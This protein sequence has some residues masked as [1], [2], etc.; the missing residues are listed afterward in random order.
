MQCSS[1]SFP[2]RGGYNNNNFNRSDVPSNWI[3]NQTIGDPNDMFR[4]ISSIS[5][6]TSFDQAFKKIDPIIEKI[7]YIN[8]NDVLHN[9]LG[10]STLEENI[11][12][13]KLYIDSIDRDI[14]AYP[15]PFNFVVHLNSVAPGV[16]RTVVPSKNNPDRLESSYMHSTPQ[17]SLNTELKRVKYIRLDSVV[18]PQHASIT[19]ENSRYIYDVSNNLT[20]DR[21]VMIEIDELK[22]SDERVYCTS[23]NSKNRFNKSVAPFGLIFPD[24]RLGS[25]YYSGCLHGCNKT[26]LTQALGHIQRLSIKFYDSF[27]DLLNPDYN[28]YDYHE[29]DK[30]DIRH[31]LNKNIQTYLVFVVGIVK[32]VLN[33][34]VTY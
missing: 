28:K 34:N 4:P 10:V 26:Y 24:R 20:D 5:N 18:L 27:G 11:V 15:N 33:T 12:E 21:F 17:P 19:K 8:K 14:K 25:K 1:N 2:N 16:I 6:Y 31:P 9:N 32:P 30:C 29:L 13:Y 3:Q 22:D 23:D 7:S